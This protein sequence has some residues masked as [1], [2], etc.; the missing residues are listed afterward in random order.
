MN[1]VSDIAQRSAGKNKM[2]SGMVQ[3]S[4]PAKAKAS[5]FNYD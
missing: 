5:A 3:A 2:P 1:K 4:A